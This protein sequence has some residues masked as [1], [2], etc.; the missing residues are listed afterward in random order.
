M[1]TPTGR[2]KLAALQAQQARAA[3][4]KKLLALT[5]GAVVVV[6]AIVAVFFFAGRSNA[7]SANKKAVSATSGAA[8][9]HAVQQIPATTYDAVGA[10]SATSAPKAV[11]GAALTKN[12]KPEVLYIGAE[13]CPYCGMERWALTAALSR[14]GT[15]SGLAPAVST[16]HDNPPNIPTMSYLKAKYSSKYLAFTSF[17]T[18]DRDGKPLQTPSQQAQALI[19]KYDQQGAIPFIDYGN[20]SVASG[21]T[22][23]GAQFMANRSGDA[24]AEKLKDPNSAE[25]QG[26]LGAANTIT[27]Q[28]CAMTKGEPSSVCTSIGVA[29]AAALKR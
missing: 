16:Q 13:F 9:I 12:G 3:R 17:E 2:E 23:Q 11:K 29:R 18:Q 24:V 15:F 5:S 21:A 7:D 26:I 10:G 20:L 8:Y 28:L 4:Q 27:N 19:A 25:A 14:F 1:S 22:F 6:L